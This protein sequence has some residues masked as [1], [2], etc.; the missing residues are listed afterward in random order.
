MSDPRLEKL[1]DI[2]VNYCTSVKPGDWV[3]VRGH[4]LA[5]PLVEAVI[6]HVTRAGGNPTVLLNT[7]EL[8]ES[9]LRE[10]NEAQLTWDSPLDG[11]MADQL[12]VRIV[13]QAASN[14]RA[15]T[16]VD[17]GKQRLL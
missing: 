16:G 11:I 7:E 17:P 1:A 4:V 12:D 13:I 15:L 3:L 10:A 9:F 5:L 6:Q 2:L 14:T 8:D